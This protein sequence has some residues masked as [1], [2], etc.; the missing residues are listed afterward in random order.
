LSFDGS[1]DHFLSDEEMGHYL[2]KMC[3]EYLSF[4]ERLNHSI[5]SLSKCSLPTCENNIRRSLLITDVYLHVV[6][7]ILPYPHKALY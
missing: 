4:V 3:I 5:M 2:S 7:P 1:L 6:F